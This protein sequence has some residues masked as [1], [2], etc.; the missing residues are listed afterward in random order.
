[1]TTEYAYALDLEQG[2]PEWLQFKVGK[3]SAS[4][5]ADVTAKLANGQP[6]AT[7][8][9]YLGDITRERLSNKPTERYTNEAM[10]WGKT[11]EPK[12]RAAY[13][14]EHMVPVR[15][16]GCALHPS[17]PWSLASPDGLVGKQ[18]LL[19]IKCPHV[20]NNH[21]ELM[22]GEAKIS[23]AYY[24]QIQ[25]QLACTERAWCDFVSFD[26]EMP[27]HLQLWVQR[28]ERDDMRIGILEQEVRAF[29]DEVDSRL[30]RFAEHYPEAA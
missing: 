5:I 18:G 27:E 30:I 15:Q 17:I 7:R 28:I 12:A 4:K 13:C 3:V 8:K 23:D 22:L 21:Q 26:P 29:L 25:W 14:L 20:S 16:I 10:A 9:R 2:T 24:Q 1:M 19:E 11:H 6:G